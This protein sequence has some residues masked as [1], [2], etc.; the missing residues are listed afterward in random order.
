M[1]FQASMTDLEYVQN[2]PAAHLLH[3]QKVNAELWHQ[4]NL[5]DHERVIAEGRYVP[6]EILYSIG[7][8][9]AYRLVAPPPA[10][11]IHRTMNSRQWHNEER[12]R[13]DAR[14][15]DIFFVKDITPP[16]SR[17]TSITYALQRVDM[18]HRWNRYCVHHKQTE[19]F[20][21]TIIQNTQ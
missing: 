8:D 3:Q 1:S 18:P 15:G 5:A 4:W 10:L 16:S 11:I 9:V 7:A 17:H 14:I 19:S 6:E 13:V 21:T 2:M 12:Y 20:R